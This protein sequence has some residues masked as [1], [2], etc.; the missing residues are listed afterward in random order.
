[1]PTNYDRFSPSHPSTFVEARGGRYREMERQGR[2][3]RGRGYRELDPGK[4]D[5]DHKN[6]KIRAAIKAAGKTKKPKIRGEL[7]PKTPK[8][9]GAAKAIKRVRRANQPAPPSYQNYPSGMKSLLTRVGKIKGLVTNPPKREGGKRERKTTLYYAKKTARSKSPS[10]L[11][12]PEAASAAE[13]RSAERLRRGITAIP[14]TAGVPYRLLVRPPGSKKP[15]VSIHKRIV[16]LL[17]TAAKKSGK[18]TKGIPAILKQGPLAKLATGAAQLRNLLAKARST[19]VT[20]PSKE[21]GAT[22]G[23]PKGPFTRADRKSHRK[24]AK[25]TPEG[26]VPSIE[27]GYVNR[28]DESIPYLPQNLIDRLLS[29]GIDLN[30]LL[31]ESKKRKRNKKRA[32]KHA[33]REGKKAASADK[34]AKQKAKKDKKAAAKSGHRK[35]KEKTKGAGKFANDTTFKKCKKGAMI[36]TPGL[37]GSIAQDRF[38]VQRKSGYNTF[39]VRSGCRSSLAGGLRAASFKNVPAK[40]GR[41][42]RA[43][44]NRLGGVGGKSRMT[45]WSP[46]KRYKTVAPGKMDKVAVQRYAK[47]HGISVQD[48]KRHFRDKMSKKTASVAS[49]HGKSIRGAK[50]IMG[51]GRKLL[52]RDLKPHTDKS[53]H[54]KPHGPRSLTPAPGNAALPTAKKMSKRKAK[55][56]AAGRSAGVARSK[57][58]TDKYRGR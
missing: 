49:K 11:K 56:Q 26:A 57:K 33:A 9:A 46:G 17:T 27:G 36:A 13:K 6:L 10:L 55:R 37:R 43:R 48:A 32:R 15:T 45:A 39:A 20:E 51:G 41:A 28:N 34:K 4:P 40:H 54:G 2:A 12:A 24:R 8:V 7:A 42:F 50:K 22:T 19:Q 52:K 1:M 30:S 21:S 29:E 47:K 5:Q 31:I 23:A 35:K 16:Q 58:F 14:K 53:E 44:V 38:V 25:S 3:G 18:S